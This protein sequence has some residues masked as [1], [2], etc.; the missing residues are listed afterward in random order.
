MVAEV[1]QCRNINI[2]TVIGPLQ[3]SSSPPESKTGRKV[4]IESSTLYKKRP[5]RHAFQL[6][7]G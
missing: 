3:E 5:S 7:N 6:E 4:L 2:C 1:D